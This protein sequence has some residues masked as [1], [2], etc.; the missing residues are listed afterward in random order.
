[1]GSRAIGCCH[2]YRSEAALSI[3]ISTLP[4]AQFIPP[5]L[6]GHETI[7]INACWRRKSRRSTQAHRKFSQVLKAW[8]V[9]Y[10]DY[11]S[12]VLPSCPLIP[13]PEEDVSSVRCF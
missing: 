13:I 8:H 10:I 6:Q 1:M 2:I 9:E 3:R 12:V 7:Q 4:R 11:C 5:V